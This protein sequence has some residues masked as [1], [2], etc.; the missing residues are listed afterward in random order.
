MQAVSVCIT[1]HLKKFQTRQSEFAHQIQVK[2]E[3]GISKNRQVRFVL[4]DFLWERVDSR[5]AHLK[6]A[7]RAV[8]PATKLSSARSIF[9]YHAK[10]CQ[11]EQS[12]CRRAVLISTSHPQTKKLHPFRVVLFIWH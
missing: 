11:T 3:K 2:S 12:L 9:I 6:T 7:H 10:T 4:V 5:A 8:F 1:K